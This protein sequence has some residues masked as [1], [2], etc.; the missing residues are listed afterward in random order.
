MIL[1]HDTYSYQGLSIHEVLYQKLQWNK[2]NRSDKSEG[3][4]VKRANNS[5]NMNYKFMVFVHDTSSYQGL[6]IYEVSLQSLQWNKSYSPDKNRDGLTDGRTDGRT[7]RQ[8]DGRTRAD[9]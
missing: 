3:K 1:V 7:D 6:F 4:K 9:L 2:S 5:K 8:T